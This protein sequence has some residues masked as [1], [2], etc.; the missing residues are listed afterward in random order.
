[1]RGV[2]SLPFEAPWDGRGARGPGL[3]KA[4]MAVPIMTESGVR[5]P[6]VRPLGPL[7][8][9]LALAAALPLAALAQGWPTKPV[10]I[11]VSTGPGL[12]TDLV[13]RSLADRLSR[14]LGQ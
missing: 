2:S 5:F 9:V 7:L 1:M 12:S 11:V 8:A 10:K 14:S 13:A 3:R 4:T 6:S